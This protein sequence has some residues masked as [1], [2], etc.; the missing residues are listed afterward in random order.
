M[1]PNTKD[2]KIPKPGNLK[3]TVMK[4]LVVVLR[5]LSPSQIRART[6]CHSREDELLG[7]SDSDMQWEPKDKSRDSD[8]IA[9][10]SKPGPSKRRKKD[11][12]NEITLK[13][14]RT[15]PKTST[16]TATTN[17]SDTKA[18]TPTANSTATKTSTQ[19]A[20]PKGKGAQ[21]NSQRWDRKICF[22]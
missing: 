2:D 21:L 10:N 3:K 6:Q 16:Q 1:L 14:V 17:S 11:H 9:T 8:Y 4:E 19:P 5:R 12:R 15:G 13:S 22:Y 20:G 18:S 7:D